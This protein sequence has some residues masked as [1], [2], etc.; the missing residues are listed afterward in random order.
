MA[1]WDAWQVTGPGRRASL[2]PCGGGLIKGLMVQWAG[3]QTGHLEV[4]GRVQLAAALLGDLKQLTRP[5]SAPPA[6][7]L[8]PV[9]QGF[10]EGMLMEWFR[11]TWM[12]QG[13]TL[14][15]SCHA[16]GGW[17]HLEPSCWKCLKNFPDTPA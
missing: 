7:C 1:D 9:W 6:A 8:L 15:H 10:L 14:S 16:R 3:H 2:Q 4:W 12:L 17:G 5:L 13:L 11:E